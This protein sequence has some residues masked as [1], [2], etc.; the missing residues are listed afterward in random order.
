MG[1]SLIYG[2]TT[3]NL[4]SPSV[5][6]QQHKKPNQRILDTETGKRFVV[7]RTPARKIFSLKW[8]YLRQTEFEQLRSF[9]ENTVNFASIP[10]TYQDFNG[11]NN[12]VRCISFSFE[13]ISPTLFS[14]SLRL[15]EE[16]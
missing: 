5:P 8:N 2:S 9:I 16:L 7:E 6:Y 1:V 3:V 10:F 11:V 13:Q 12:N 15:E 4:P 14:V